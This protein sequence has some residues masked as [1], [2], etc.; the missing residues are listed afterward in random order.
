MFTKKRLLYA[1]DRIDGVSIP[2]DRTMTANAQ[3]V[4]IKME[5]LDNSLRYVHLPKFVYNAIWTMPK[6]MEM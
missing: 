6:P 1:G 5:L 2:R 4:H 3:C